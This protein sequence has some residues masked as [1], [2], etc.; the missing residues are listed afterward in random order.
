MM[1]VN[2]W[3]AAIPALEEATNSRKRKVRGRA[4]HNL[5]VIYE[6]LGD[7]KKAKEWAQK[8]WGMHRNKDSKEYTYRLNQRIREIERLE[9]QLE[10]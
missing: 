9:A 8:A 5:A 1:E 3:D 2:D 10:N 4:A 7:Y 6:I